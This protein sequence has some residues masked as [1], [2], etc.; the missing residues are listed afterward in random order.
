MNKVEDS[1]SGRPLLNNTSSTL[2]IDLYEEP[3]G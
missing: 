2:Q 3:G 1:T